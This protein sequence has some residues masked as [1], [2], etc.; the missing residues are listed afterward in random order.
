M[1]ITDR[2][3]GRKETG[4]RSALRPSSDISNKSVFIVA[5]IGGFITA[6]LAWMIPISVLE[7]ITGATGL[8]EIIP[9]TGAPLGSSAKILFIIF[10]A[11]FI[12]IILLL[13][14][15]GMRKAGD[16][17]DIYSQDEN[18]NNFVRERNRMP[19]INNDAEDAAL[20]QKLYMQD[21]E[22]P[23]IK[24]VD[25]RDRDSIVD[26]NVPDKING[27]AIFAGILGA[28]VAKG[29]TTGIV[30]KKQ[31]KKLPF[32]GGDD[33]VRS[34]DD[35]PKLR[36]ADKHPDAS[37][38]RPLFANED[39]GEKIL[40]RQDDN[41]EKTSQKVS[42]EAPLDEFLNRNENQSVADK[43]NEEAVKNDDIEDVI[44][45]NQPANIPPVIEDAAE[46]MDDDVNLRP[47]ATD[48]SDAAENHLAENHAAEN[49][50]AENDHDAQPISNDSELPS[51]ESLVARMEK[52][53]MRQNDATANDVKADEI[54]EAS[55]EKF[56]A[57]AELERYDEAITDSADMDEEDKAS[58]M[59]YTPYEEMKSETEAETG[60]KNI[61]P[62]T[63]TNDATDSNDAENSATLK[64]QKE[65]MDAALKSALET[66]HKMTQKSA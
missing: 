8:S 16:Q 51:L 19:I 6:I 52:I 58:D 4:I 63:D 11:I 25:F 39:L 55:D 28:V 1:G 56:A 29:A 13:L 48:S 10:S 57:K 18:P 66:L 14:L 20:G 31:I 15:L 12:T 41:I 33:R 54:I 64:N 36:D 43:V 59:Q 27:K 47:M 26:E 49:H 30:L 22:L 21:K 53:V 3:M 50:A 38:R 32:M 45:E 2:L 34:F 60:E 61:A 44:F 9:A 42:E 62:K 5:I 40:D 17:E 37:P 65:E 7:A 23:K 35:L 46:A 24:T